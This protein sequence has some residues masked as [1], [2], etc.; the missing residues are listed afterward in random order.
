MF[1]I[2][3]ISWILLDPSG[4]NLLWNNSTCCLSYT[5]NI[6]PADALVTSGA[7]ASEELIIIFLYWLF[8]V[9]QHNYYPRGRLCRV[10][11]SQTYY[12][13]DP[14]TRATPLLSKK[15]AIGLVLGTGVVNKTLAGELNVFISRD[16][17]Y[18]WEEVGWC[19]AETL[20][21]G[22]TSVTC[23]YRHSASLTHCGL[24]MLY[25]NIALSQHWLR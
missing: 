7:R 1:A 23:Y 11:L 9:F 4:G 19:A 13:Y 10:H 20:E 21:E 14:Y 3:I 2:W 8:I 17:G 24:V 5:A 25:G 6:T 18:H 22:I 16:G 12:H 15:S